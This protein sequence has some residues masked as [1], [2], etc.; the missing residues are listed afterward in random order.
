MIYSVIILYN[1]DIKVHER[2]DLISNECD[3]V[4]VVV[5]SDINF[6]S[7]SGKFKKNVQFNYLESNIGLAKAL[8]IGIKECLKDL[9]CNYICLFDQDTTPPK[10]SIKHIVEKFNISDEKIAAIGHSLDYRKDLEKFV[11]VEDILTSGTIV[12]RNVLENVGLM[13]ETLFIDYLDYEWC[14]RAKASKY[15]I[16]SA[17]EQVLD[18]K[19]G[20]ESLNFVFFKKPF[21]LNNIRH[22]YIIRNAL[23]LIN[24]S[25]IP[26]IWKVKH[27]VKTV[28]RIPIYIIY[29]K[30]KA[31][32]AILIFQAIKDFKINKEIYKMPKY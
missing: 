17:T 26:L 22:Y 4:I 29:S 5:N 3:K 27:F 25:Y 12:P 2:I 16:Y 21:H 32:K 8:N 20:D 1:P 31:K 11:E 6:F 28:Y 15:K 19:L 18:H 10:N 14:L 23:I 9:N 7:R 30:D 24:R 13:D